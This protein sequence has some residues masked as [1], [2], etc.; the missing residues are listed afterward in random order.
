[1]TRKYKADAPAAIV[2]DSKDDPDYQALLTSIQK[3]HDYFYKN[4]RRFDMPNY[5]PNAYLVRYWKNWGILPKDYDVA[6]DGWDAEKM[7]DLYFDH[8]IW[9]ETGP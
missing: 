8:A 6:K 7:D 1:M 5:Q 4:I 9:P 3:A 2:F